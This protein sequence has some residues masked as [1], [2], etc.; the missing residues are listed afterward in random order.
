MKS[1]NQPQKK[2]ELDEFETIG[3]PITIN[4]SD[5]LCNEWMDQNIEV[6]AL[7]RKMCKQKEH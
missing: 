2:V 1:E 5:T 6:W 3:I 7:I 4:L